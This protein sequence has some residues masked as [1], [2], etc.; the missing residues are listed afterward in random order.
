MGRPPASCYANLVFDVAPAAA[1]T[2]GGAFGFFE[3]IV[4]GDKALVFDGLVSRRSQEDRGQGG[5]ARREGRPV[6]LKRTC[7]IKYVNNFYF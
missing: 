4:H 2:F 7:L 3:T 5:P 1:L 6:K